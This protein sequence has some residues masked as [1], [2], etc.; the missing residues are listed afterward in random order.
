MNQ[1]RIAFFLA[2]MMLLLTPALSV[3]SP[4]DMDGVD[5]EKRGIQPPSSLNIPGFQEGSIF[6]NDTLSNGYEHSCLIQND[7][8]VSCWG[9]DNYGVGVL[10]NGAAT[11]QTTPTQVSSFG[12]NRT[13]VSVSGGDL[14]TCSILNTGEVSCW[15]Y[16]SVGLLGNGGTSD[17]YTP[18]D[19]SSLGPG[20]K[21]VS[22]SSG[23]Y[24]T[25]VI[26]DNGEVSCW[27]INEAG[28]LGRGTTSSYELTPST[29]SS[30]GNGRQAVAISAGGAH[31]CALLD[32]GEVSC[33]GYGGF[34]QL[35]IG[36]TSNKSI[37]TPTSSFGQDVT[38][39]AISSGGYHT[40]AILS[41]GSVSC[42]GEN[43]DGQLG[44]GGATN[45]LSPTLVS[46]LGANRTAIAISSGY[47]Y[48][49]VIL[50]T[51]NVSCWGNGGDG[52]LTAAPL[53]QSLPLPISNMAPGRTIVG[54]SAG[55]SHTCAIL[56][57]GTVSCWG[58]G[59]SGQL[60]D[61]QATYKQTTPTPISSLGAGKSIAISERDLDNDGKLN[62][63][64]MYPYINSPGF[65]EASL[66]T[67]T[68]L[69]SGGAHGCALI[70]T[71]KVLCWG[72]NTY[73]QLGYGG[74]ATTSTPIQTQNFGSGKFPTEIDAGGA[75]TCA[76]LNTGEVSCWGWNYGGAIGDGTTIDRTTPRLTSSL[77]NGKSAVAISAG[78]FHTCAILDTGEVSCWGFNNYGQ[79][80][81][82]GTNDQLTPTLTSNLGNGRAAIAISSGSLLTCAVLDDLSARCWGQGH[83]T[84]PS[85][86]SGLGANTDV[87]AISAGRKHACALLFTGNVS[88]WGEGGLGQLG[89]G[90]TLSSSSAVP[91]SGFG[92]ERYATAI[93]A[94]D[95]HTCA[96][97][98]NG[99]ISCWGNNGYGQLGD[100][101]ISGGANP[102]LVNFSLVESPAI[103]IASGSYF[104]CAL[105]ETRDVTCW[106][107]GS[108]GQM[109]GTFLTNRY[110]PIISI[111]EFEN[112]KI[113][114][115]ERDSDQDGIMNIFEG[116]MCTPGTYKVGENCVSTDPGY[117]TSS[118][119]AEQQT[120]CP[121][122]TFQG[123]SKQASCKP[124]D[125]GYFVN[126]TL[127][128]AQIAQ[129]PCPSG[130][131][132]PLNGSTSESDCVSTEPG[133]YTNSSN[134]IGNPT[135][136]A[137]DIGAYQDKYGQDSCLLADLGHFVNPSSTGQTNQTPC[138][139]DEYQNEVG[140]TSCKQA[141]IGHYVDA[142]SGVGNVNQIPCPPGTYQDEIGQIECKDA[143]VG[144]YVD[145]TLGPAQTVQSPCST[146]LFQDEEGQESCKVARPGHYVPLAAGVGQ[147]SQTKCP[148]GTFNPNFGGVS[149]D[150]C[151]TADEGHFVNFSLGD[152]QTNQT[153]CPPGTFNP[154]AASTFSNDCRSAIEGFYV[155][156]LLGPGQINQTKC[157]SGTYNPNEGA[158][159]ISHCILSDPGYYSNSTSGIPI[160]QKSCEKG[161]YQP[162]AG[163]ASCLISDVGY[164]V[165]NYSSIEQ[166]PCPEGTYQ[167]L[168][169]QIDCLFADPGYYVGQVGQS[170]PT[171]CPEGTYSDRPAMSECLEAGLGYYVED[172]DQTAKIQCPVNTYTVVTN[173]SSGTTWNNVSY[174][175]TDTDND[176]LVDDDNA[177]NAD[178]DDDN[179]GFTD[180]EDAF[181]LDAD[182][183]IDENGDG[184]GDN[185]KPLTLYEN[186]ALSIGEPLLISLIILVPLLTGIVAVKF[187]RSKRINSEDES[188]EPQQVDEQIIPN[189]AIQTPP[190]IPAEGIPPGWTMEQWAYYG[191]EW[192]AMQAN[193]TSE[194]P[195][196]TVDEEVYS[197]VLE[198]PDIPPEESDGNSHNLI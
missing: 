88:C 195:V 93:S 23:G 21:A 3:N 44:N 56:D 67:D 143:D 84:T 188:T 39:I 5:L 53:I 154:D 43:G 104:T 36:T 184:I 192:L 186:M 197:T 162:E 51:G 102:T 190:P 38:A 111:T 122:G 106:G 198:T 193:P 1:R 133:H 73:G 176:G 91:T 41:N 92:P 83:G 191:N 12:N 157:P 141:D 30:L 82:G 48:T 160:N 34:G 107:Q 18:V 80:G 29:T 17:Q 64:D 59:S 22:I 72:D 54:L 86:V 168:P 145:P 140:K 181:P 69:T 87:V 11:Y 155:D 174:C 98:D 144:H 123:L 146:G 115:S 152:A 178:D 75:H 114:L 49:C 167:P 130:T 129:T 136:I 37:P 103:A 131:Y 50:D 177:I 105:L 60:G 169:G 142:M 119:G 99:S 68:T 70:E 158:T 135:Q 147:S 81:N 46:S 166:T 127:G 32:N 120:P 65:Q 15:G 100:G 110:Q 40:C 151:L 101:T 77:G 89:T 170:E 26:L 63:F 58:R 90:N 132:N 150:V 47:D 78:Q 118:Y 128:Q 74:S 2:I 71:R 24:H 25:C 189:P 149:P 108:A 13:A 97:L 112:S 20:R 66:F 95:D 57:N 16:G 148:P 33:W 4:S 194:E 173:N 126:T 10:G 42:W 35:G 28:R 121:A 14:H 156:E 6:T 139:E 52:Q 172:S 45:Q 9:G 79:I 196:A 165:E 163:Q 117:F 96:L 61:G 94:G 62:I 8:N 109:G 185:E 180:K 153:A 55:D 85:T 113:V 134:G 76:I 27:G 183:W 179:D 137:C 171:P 164:Y 7:G 175:W 19:T 124:A 187:A 161:T 31:T 125:A 182:E 116:I 159:L 138:P